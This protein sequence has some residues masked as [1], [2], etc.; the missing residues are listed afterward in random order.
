V[1][2]RSG[3]QEKGRREAPCQ[4]LRRAL[5]LRLVSRLF[6][7]PDGIGRAASDAVEAAA[8]SVHVERVDGVLPPPLRP[9]ALLRQKQQGVKSEEV[10]STALHTTSPHQDEQLRPQRDGGK[11]LRAPGR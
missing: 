2:R 11:S 10:L 8:A 4:A 5:Y 3:R 9:K 6:R 7:T 1:V